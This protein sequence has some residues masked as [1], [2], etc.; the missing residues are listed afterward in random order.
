MAAA[1]NYALPTAISQSYTRAASQD[2]ADRGPRE[3]G[4]PQERPDTWEAHSSAPTTTSTP[5]R[6]THSPFTPLPTH[7]TSP[8]TRAIHEPSDVAQ[9]LDPFVSHSA[10]S[11]GDPYSAPVVQVVT[12]N[13]SETVGSSRAPPRGGTL[14]NRRKA[15]LNAVNPPAKRSRRAPQSST[16]GNTGPQVVLTDES[17]GFESLDDQPE[18]QKAM[19]ALVAVIRA[20]QSFINKEHEPDLGTLEADALMAVASDGLWRGYGTKAKSI[21]S[22]FIKVDG[23]EFKCLWCGDV[24][25]DKL[26]RAVGHFRAKH[27][28]HEPFLCGETHASHEIWCVLPLGRLERPFDFFDP[29]TSGLPAMKLWGST[30][31]ERSKSRSTGSFSATDG[32]S[33]SLSL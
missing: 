3:T 22:L 5:S 16:T 14:S 9:H 7:Q 13:P 27:L 23:K 21:Y 25:K 29:A 19:R 28:G 10:P 4:V 32:A 1:N 12:I 8:P 15:S 2:T 30:R 31:E 11:G 33:R 6:T 18:V 26:Q 20:S 24:Q 17:L